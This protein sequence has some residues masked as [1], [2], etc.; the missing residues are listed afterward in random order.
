MR[1]SS[2]ASSCVRSASRR[3][4]FG[5]RTVVLHAVPSPHPRFDA[6][7]CFRELVADLA[8]GRFGGWANRLER[9]AATYA[10]R[11]AVKAGQR[12]EP[13]RDAGAAAPPVRHGAP[14]ARRARALDDRA[15]AA[16]GAGAPVWP[17]V[18]S[19]SW[20][21]PP[22]SA[23]PRWRLALAA[24]WPLEIVSADSRQ[25]YR[26]LDIGTAK[27]TRKERAR[28]AH[29]G[30]DLVDPGTRYSAG[31]FARDAVGWLADVRGRGRLPVVVGGTGL[32]VRALAEGLF[33]RAAARCRAPPFARRLHRA[34]RA[35]RAA[36]LGR[37]ARS[38]LPRRWATARRPRHRGRAADGPPA[39]LLASGGARAK[40]L[41]SRGT[42]C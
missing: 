24:H 12:L 40:R 34:A 21:G 7:A 36:P 30:L 17:A 1:S 23:R 3:R 9:F 22:R 5:G 13:A 2:T 27:P 35:A 41:W 29:H 32:Y 38:R 28:V 16:R 15:V 14:A 42:L 8:R 37:S 33:Q 31:H 25:I 18:G 10:C 19:R 20:W 39:L 11:A 4:P 26:R 6:G